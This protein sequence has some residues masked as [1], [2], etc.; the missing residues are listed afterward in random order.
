MRDP[1]ICDELKRRI[2]HL[3]RRLGNV[4]VTLSIL[5]CAAIFIVFDLV[6]G[7]RWGLQIGALVALAFGFFAVRHM[8]ER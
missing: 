2:E 5:G 8:I 6:G 1:D 7:D 3:E 4:A